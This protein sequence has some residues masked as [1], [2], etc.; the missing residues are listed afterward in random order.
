MFRLL[1]ID[2]RKY[3]YNKTFWVLV[4]IY[5]VLNVVAFS[6]ME[7]A[8]NGLRNLSRKFDD[9]IFLNQLTKHQK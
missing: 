5:V 6:V 8:L 9:N 3:F 7:K 4:A 1:K 2:F